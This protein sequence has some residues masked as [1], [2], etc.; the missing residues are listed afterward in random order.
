MLWKQAETKDVIK[1]SWRVYFVLA[2]S[3]LL[4]TLVF[5]LT[6]LIHIKQN[7]FFPYQETWVWTE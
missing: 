5:I 2:I 1:Q 6:D 4:Q 3:F 7:R